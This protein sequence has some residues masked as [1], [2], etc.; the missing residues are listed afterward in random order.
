MILDEINLMQKIQKLNF[1]EPM[2]VISSPFNTGGFIVMCI[3][4]YLYKI[5]NYNDIYLLTQGCIVGNL[6]KYIFK[7]LR[8]YNA[9]SNIKNFSGKIHN[10]TTDFYSFPSGH[11][12]AATFFC[13][14]MLK[15]YPTEFIFNIVAILVGF[16]RIFLGVHYPTD[17]IGGIIYAFLFYNIL[18]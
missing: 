9:N 16:S 8:P 15:K 10:H 13:L 2:R 4:L 14:I 11:T 5:L 17:I 3:V 7:R 12:F 1:A 18:S 6:L